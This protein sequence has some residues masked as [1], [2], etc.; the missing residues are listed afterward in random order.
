LEVP[1]A[2]PTE[3][4]P[5]GLPKKVK[6]KNKKKAKKP[7]SL[8]ERLSPKTLIAFAVGTAVLVAG[9]IVALVLL[10]AGG[11]GNAGDGGTTEGGTQS[12]A[13]ADFVVVD[14]SVDGVQGPAAQDASTPAPPRKPG[15]IPP[16]RAATAEVEPGWLLQPDPP[17]S[18]PAVL[19]ERWASPIPGDWP[20]VFASMAGPFYGV[21]G[22]PVL[23]APQRQPGPPP[24]P[25]PAALITD[26]RTGKQSGEFYHAFLNGRLSPD[27]QFIVTPSAFPEAHLTEKE[28]KLLVYKDKETQRK[29][30]IEIPGAVAWLD[31]IAADRVA[32]YT[33][34]PKPVVHIHTI[35]DGK[36]AK[37]IPIEAEMLPA[38]EPHSNIVGPSRP[39][40]W[41]EPKMLR[42]AVSPGG[43]YLALGSKKGI[44]VLSLAEGRQLMELV[45]GEPGEHLGINFNPDGTELYS[46][47]SRLRGWSLA[48]GQLLFSAPVTQPLVGLPVKGPEPGTMIVGGTV[49][50]TQAGLAIYYLDFT[51][52]RWVGPDSLLAYG[53]LASAPYLTAPAEKPLPEK[54]ATS[55][56]EIVQQR[57]NSLQNANSNA[58]YTT[59]LDRAKYRAKADPILAAVAPR[60]VVPVGDRSGVKSLKA[61]PPTTW[62]AP[63]P[64]HVPEPSA[65]KPALPSWPTTMSA[66]HA[67]MITF[68]FMQVPRWQY[69]VNWH[70]YDLR[71]GKKVGDPIELWPWAEMTDRHVTMIEQFSTP[72]AAL[73]D[74][75]GLL[76]L[77]DPGDSA[78]LNVWDGSGKRLGGLIPYGR[79]VAADWLGWSAD[80][81]LLT[82]GAGRLTGWDWK[83]ARAIWEVEGGYIT[84]VAQAPGRAWLAAPAGDAV[85]LLDA[86]SGRCLARCKAPPGAEYLALAVSLNGAALAAAR[87]E[88]RPVAQAGAYTA[89]IWDLT[90][91][92]GGFGPLW[93]RQVRVS[94]LE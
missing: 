31:F 42:G 70:R 17:A 6:K 83:A 34:D 4:R 19:P 15:K 32:I 40:F 62:T 23:P 85:D 14:V 1:L 82:L 44:V 38:P 81:R 35:A 33:F 53:K 39:K 27:G 26:L 20:P 3:D 24:K 92:K 13:R 72:L 9:G 41:Y 90:N 2:E 78:R 71:A 57:L 43:R 29:A 79:G 10:L 84:P 5:D 88:K 91:G 93:R 50:E 60:P 67:A 22:P 94:P 52:V 61:E 65:V 56:R 51:A 76:A 18:A 89:D 87:P 25:T 63:P 21:L 68:D 69:A 37:T 8:I 64:A 46:V 36:L 86:S 75:G 55:R 16:L 30:M 45:L 28:G 47:H 49:V 66:D 48:S 74:D 54:N 59:P 80:G 58:V 77:R 7:A 73:T 11:G 12:A